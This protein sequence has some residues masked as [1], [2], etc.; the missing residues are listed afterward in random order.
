MNNIIFVLFFFLSEQGALAQA[1]YCYSKSLKIRPKDT[2]VIF[3]RFTF[4]FSSFFFSFFQTKQNKT[5]C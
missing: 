2:D 1:A 5:K 3:S 4:F